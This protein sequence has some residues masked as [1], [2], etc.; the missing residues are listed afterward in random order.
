MSSPTTSGTRRLKE[1]ATQARVFAVAQELP[2]QRPS[3]LTTDV[4]DADRA[5]AISLLA[6]RR[7][8]RPDFKD[9]GDGV[10]GLFRRATTKE[11]LNNPENWTFSANELDE[12]L[13]AVVGYAEPGMTIII[14]VC[15]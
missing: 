15:Y 10:K 13:E 9:A 5:Q 8:Q 4:S 11:K 1:L 6:E 14:S 7:R 12:G 3:R 2:L